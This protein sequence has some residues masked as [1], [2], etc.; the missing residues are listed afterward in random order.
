[1]AGPR[2][3]LAGLTR[4]QLENFAVQ[5]MTE[6]PRGST[7]ASWLNA[8]LA[9]ASPIPAWAVSAVL[10]HEDL[11]AEVVSHLDM[12]DYSAAAVCRLWH[13]KW[14]YLVVRQRILKTI[15]VWAFSTAG[16]KPGT[17]PKPANILCLPEG[18]CVSMPMDKCLMMCD[19][20]SV[21]TTGL[22]HKHGALSIRKVF[23]VQDPDSWL[24]DLAEGANGSVF[25][26]DI[27]TSI[28]RKLRLS[29]LDGTFEETVT[30]V[31]TD[32]PNKDEVEDTGY[33]HNYLQ[34]CESILYVVR[35]PLVEA[36]DA[37]TLVALP[38]AGFI[39]DMESR[40]PF[41]SF[42]LSQ[43]LCY[44]GIAE[45]L[46][47]I[48]RSGQLVT[49]PHVAHTHCPFEFDVCDGRLYVLDECSDDSDDS[50][51]QIRWLELLSL[52]LDGRPTQPPLN[53]RNYLPADDGDVAGYFSLNATPNGIFITDWSNGKVCRV[54]F[55]GQEGLAVPQ[56]GQDGP[57]SS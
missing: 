16:F 40:L 6:L 52:T 57:S 9:V 19:Y 41:E 5:A 2:A 35:P 47:A 7:A 48:N 27:Q 44:I 31:L 14:R 25:C 8:A 45:E 15:D 12:G 11:S 56:S 1:M 54:S 42:D 53:L 43:Q 3:R 17:M 10:L 55:A 20:D 49:L 38:Q 22:R 50:D 36:F 13:Q 18:L 26:Y 4:E 39:L 34:L 28:L 23:T 30:I 21:T 24:Y 32:D 29:P 33:C 37:T 51:D 46:L